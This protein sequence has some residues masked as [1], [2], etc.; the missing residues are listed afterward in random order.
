MTQKIVG[1]GFQTQTVE[2]DTDTIEFDGLDGEN[3]GLYEIIFSILK[4]AAGLVGY[5]IQP[6]GI[7]TDQVSID[8]YVGGAAPTFVPYIPG[9][10]L[11]FAASG[12][13]V[14]DAVVGR[15][16][17][18]PKSGLQRMGYSDDTQFDGTNVYKSFHA[19]T[20]DDTSTAISSMVL[21]SDVAGG[22]KAGTIIT[23][24]KIGQ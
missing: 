13:Q 7:S 11:E 10:T 20:W 23:L 14:G 19:F 24:R 1:G 21:K 6:N 17:F 15:A 3:D 4:G 12:G 18:A 2:E 22:F 9:T 8:S 16:S 5:S